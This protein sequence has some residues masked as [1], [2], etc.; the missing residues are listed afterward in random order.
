MNGLS[1]ALQPFSLARPPL[2]LV[3]TGNLVGRAHK[4]AIHYVLRG[5]LAELVIPTRSPLPAR[6]NGLWNETCFEFFLAVKNSPEYWE[7]NLAPA[8]HWN[9]YR[10]DAYRQGMGEETAF[11]SLPFRV[12]YQRD[13]LLLAL[14]LDLAGI[15]QADQLL[16][17]AIAAV[18]KPRE[19]E[20]TYWALTHRSPQPD[21]HRRDSFILNYEPT[22]KEW[23]VGGAVVSG[24][25]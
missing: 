24:P 9:V 7:F 25:V 12:R 21:F 8:G 3:L 4:V 17:M 5:R 15:V 14:E 6:R 22:K 18:I 19:G 10:F 11:T 20:V 23:R 13:S 16:E 1:F 2:P